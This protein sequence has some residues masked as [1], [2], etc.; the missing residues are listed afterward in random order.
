LGERGC[1]GTRTEILREQARARTEHADPCEECAMRQFIGS[2]DSA[3]KSA[4]SMFARMIAAP[5]DVAHCTRY[6]RRS[7]GGFAYAPLYCTRRGTIKR[8]NANGTGQPRISKTP[9]CFGKATEEVGRASRRGKG[10][11]PYVGYCKT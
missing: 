10:E 5:R 2:H 8:L 7:V 11:A 4:R 6:R 3:S 1:G 9:P